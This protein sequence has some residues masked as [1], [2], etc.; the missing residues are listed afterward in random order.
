M[1][2]PDRLVAARWASAP[3]ADVCEKIQD[4]THFSPKTQ[5]TDGQYP[6]HHGEER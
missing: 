3:L 6:I 1:N 2:P 5:L 4:G